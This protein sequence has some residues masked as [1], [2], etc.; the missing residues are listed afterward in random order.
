MGLSLCDSDFALYLHAA[1]PSDLA[2]EAHAHLID[3]CEEALRM[4]RKGTAESRALSNAAA[5]RKRLALWQRAKLSWPSL[6]AP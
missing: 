3:A 4:S 2:S 5:W 6:V 1:H